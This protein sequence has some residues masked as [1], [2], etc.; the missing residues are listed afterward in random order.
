MNLIAR[1]FI[2][3]EW[4]QKELIEAKFRGEMKDSIELWWKILAKYRRE[5]ENDDSD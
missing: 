5:K 1:D 3:I 2:P 4:L